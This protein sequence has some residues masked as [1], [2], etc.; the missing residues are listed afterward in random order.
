MANPWAFPWQSKYKGKVAILDDYREGLT[1]GLMKN[2][3]F[4]PNTTDQPRSSAATQAL[5]DLDS[6]VNLHIDNNDYTPIP[7]ARP[8]STRHGR[9]TWPPPPTTCPRAPRSRWSATGSRRTAWVRWP[10]TR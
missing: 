9:G 4:D 2:G 10:T 6:L 5:L 3:D 8:G 7:T 1:L